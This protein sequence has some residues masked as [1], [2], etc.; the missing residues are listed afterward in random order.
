M[1]ADEGADNNFVAN[2]GF[3][4]L[5]YFIYFFFYFFFFFFGGGESSL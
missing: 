2:D 1:S 3:K 4:W 5:F